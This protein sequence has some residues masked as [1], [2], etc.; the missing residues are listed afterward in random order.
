MMCVFIEH[1]VSL[2]QYFQ[3][4]TV[5]ISDRELI[6]KYGDVL[7]KMIISDMVYDE[8]LQTPGLKLEKDKILSLYNVLYNLRDITVGIIPLRYVYADASSSVFQ[9]HTILNATKNLRL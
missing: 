2:A 6:G 7:Y 5:N 9:I 4:K 3:K 1:L 8:V